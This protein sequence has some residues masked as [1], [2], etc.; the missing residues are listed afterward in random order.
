MSQKSRGPRH[1]AVVRRQ[2]MATI[3]LARTLLSN[4]SGS[5]LEFGDELRREAG[6]S[7]PTF[8]ALFATDGDLLLAIEQ[9]LLDECAERVRSL[10]E[11]FDP[12]EHP[13][14]PPAVA[15][16]IALADARP[17][18][19]SSLTIRLR[20]RQLAVSSGVRSQEVMASERAFLPNLIEA[21]DALTQ[22]IERRFSWQPA[23]ATRV[24]ILTY[25]RSFES[26]VLA[27]GTE[28]MFSSSPYVRQT[29]PEIILGVTEPDEGDAE[30]L[31]AS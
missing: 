11:R 13:E 17:L 6:M 1:D 9:Q 16:A 30:S 23:L 7:R 2:R 24:I 15:L 14:H 4:W 27:G 5:W 19:W 3:T 26:W 18:D 12:G 29:L 20:Q 25:E 10:A 8:R 22:R 28:Q 31:T 21:F